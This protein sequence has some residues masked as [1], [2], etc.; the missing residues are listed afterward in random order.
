MTTS[1]FPV[2][3]ATRHENSTRP[4]RGVAHGATNVVAFRTRSA[5]GIADQFAAELDDPDQVRTINCD[6]CVM[7]GSGACDECVVTFLLGL[8]PDRKL[9]EMTAPEI[10]TLAMLQATGLAPQSQFAIRPLALP[11]RRVV[12]V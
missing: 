4:K 9:V 8:A 2:R 10:D 7:Q 5:V 6:D 3:P 11:T 1:N 12:T